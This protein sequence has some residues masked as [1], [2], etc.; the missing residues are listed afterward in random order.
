MTGDVLGA[1]MW[2][3]EYVCGK[4][5]KFIADKNATEVIGFFT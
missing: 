2:Q 3:G 1:E 4:C 5:G